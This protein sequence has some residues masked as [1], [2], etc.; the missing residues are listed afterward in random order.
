[1]DIGWILC[2]FDGFW[3]YV[4]MVFGWIFDCFRKDFGW[5]FDGCFMGFGLIYDGF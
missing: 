2:L 3:M 5:M 4:G 1:M